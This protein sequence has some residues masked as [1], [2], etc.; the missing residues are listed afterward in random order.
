MVQTA[1]NGNHWV[2]LEHLIT[3]QHLAAFVV[4]FMGMAIGVIIANKR[5]QGS[6]GG[7]GAIMGKSA[8]DMCALKDKCKETDQELCEETD[9]D[10]TEC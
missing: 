9:C 1:P 4:A 10:E 8:C 7:I 6:C 2:I 5:I 3:Q